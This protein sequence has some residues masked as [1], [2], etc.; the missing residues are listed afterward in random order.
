MNSRFNSRTVCESNDDAGG[1]AASDPTDYLGLLASDGRDGAD[2]I[3]DAVRAANEPDGG[4]G[5]GADDTRGDSPAPDATSEEDGS[6][7]LILG[8]FRD[9]SALE[10]SYQSLEGEYTQTRQRLAEYEQQLQALTQQI[11]QPQRPAFDFDAGSG[12]NN[13]PQD[14]EQLEA[15][16]ERD[17]SAAAMWAMRNAENLPA[18]LV[19]E[20]VNYW[21][22]RNPAQ[23]NAFMLQQ[24]LQS[25]LP[26]FQQ[27]IDPVVQDHTE[28]RIQAA[29]NMAEQTIGPQYG[30][31]HD[32]I[33]E[34][35]EQ[36]PSL[37]PDDPND[38]RQMHDALVQVY[39]MLLGQDL[40]A[41]GAAAQGTA[42]QPGPQPP[43]PATTATRTTAAQPT[44]TTDEQ[45][46]ALDKQIQD[47]ILNARG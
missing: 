28:G 17:P 40:L 44:A 45:A 38:V 3:L 8:R 5:G 47:M 41:R 1:G 23:A 2:L 6:E 37:L 42:P 18:E 34:A 14:L 4:D 11:Q 7:N 32:R 16:A 46:A 29:V 33:I 36:R 12:F 25:Y 27:Q 31:Y 21:Y 30:E 24:M 39:A 9:Q 13:E 19:Q 15:L 26:Q 20:T 35:I 22:Q 10:Q 43:S